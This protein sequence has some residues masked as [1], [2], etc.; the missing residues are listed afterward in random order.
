[1]I[2]GNITK[3]SKSKVLRGMTQSCGCLQKEHRKNW[4]ISHGLNNG[5][6]AFNELYQQY[7]VSAKRRKYEFDLSK[8]DFKNIITKPCIYCGTSLSQEKR[9]NGGHGGFKYTGIDRYDNTKGY[10]LDNSVPCCKK[11][12]RMKSDMSIEEFENMLKK[13]ILNK[14]M[15]KRTA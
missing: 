9:G 7:M 1:M 6:A 3:P 11:C 14:N 5:E 13:I 15:W 10:T 4:G 12:N 8:E 2:V